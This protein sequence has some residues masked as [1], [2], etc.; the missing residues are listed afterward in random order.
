MQSDDGMA[1]DWYND[2][3]FKEPASGRATFVMGDGSVQ[4]LS[5]EI[6]YQLYNNLGS[7]PAAERRWCFREGERAWR[8]RPREM[9]TLTGRLPAQGSGI[10]A[11]GLPTSRRP[12]CRL[13]ACN[14]R[15]LITC[16]GQIRQCRLC[17][18]GIGHVPSGIACGHCAVWRPRACGAEPITPP[19]LRLPGPPSSG[20]CPGSNRA[21]WPGM[22][23]RGCMS[24]H[25]FAFTLWAFESAKEHGFAIDQAKLDHWIGRAKAEARG[26][27]WVEIAAATPA[28]LEADGVPAAVVER[29]KPL[30]EKP[31]E[32]EPDFVAELAKLLTADEVTAYQ[33]QILKAA[34]RENDPVDTDTYAELI[35]GSVPFAASESDPAAWRSLSAVRFGRAR[36]SDG[37]WH[38][39]GGQLP[40][41][42][43][44]SPSKTPWPRCGCSWPWLRG[45]EIDAS[46]AAGA[47]ASR[48]V[49]GQP[50]RRKGPQQRMAAIAV[51]GRGQVRH[52]ECAENFVQQLRDEQCP[53]G[54]W[55]WV[56]GE[57]KSDA[58]AT[59]Q[60]LYALGKLGVPPADPAIERARGY[61]IVQQPDGS[62]TIYPDGF[63]DVPN[64]G[65]LKR[66]APIWTYW[67][68]AGHDRLA[69]NAAGLKIAA[70]G[71]SLASDTSLG[72]LAGLDD[73]ALHH[74]EEMLRSSSSGCR[75]ARRR[76][77]SAGRPACPARRVP[78]S[79]P[80][81][82]DLGA[83]PGGAGD[84]LQ[85]READVVDEESQLLGVVAVR[86]P[87]EAVVAAHADPAAGLENPARTFGAAFQRFLDGRRSTF[88]GR[89]NSGPRST[90]A[91]SNCKRGNARGVALEQQFERLVVHERAVLD[92]VVAGPQGVLDSLGRPAVAGDLQFVVVG[93]GD[94]GVHFVEGHAKRVVVVDVGRG[95]VAGRIGLDPL[96]AVL[97]QFAHGR[98]A[99]RRRR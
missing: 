18:G 88:C 62:W 48:L 87:G 83:G 61:L 52:A 93:R 29:L 47:A 41:L 73:T 6:D 7:E 68:S 9:G 8:L 65:R 12:I 26:S 11:P 66:T 72:E 3:G 99:L 64:E 80:A 54:G 95:G 5:E 42:K 77:R 90:L 14:G 79:S 20:A 36:Q 46:S 49:A 86:V 69:G 70:S 16:R 81:A 13:P 23:T 67:G 56:R 96:D 60:T 10:Q 82:H 50:G 28:A 57:K 51:A 89:P 2:C 44:P 74:G 32:T 75:P 37:H 38:G 4:F 94:D 40:C 34:N 92:R 22:D 1:T 84:R 78:N 21:A 45:P 53:D 33:P 71:R 55:S 85:R 91:S 43:R 30:A 19:S 58:F 76:R 39:A 35:L 98:R 63:N 25:T 31:F 59:G 15:A 97:D 17:G 27:A 24:C